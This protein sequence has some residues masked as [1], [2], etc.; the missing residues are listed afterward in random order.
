MMNGFD[1]VGL[2][3]T[4]VAC[5]AFGLYVYGVVMECKDIKRHKRRAAKAKAN[6]AKALD[7]AQSLI[8]YDQDMTRYHLFC[9]W[10][11]DFKEFKE[12]NNVI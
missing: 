6:K 3:A 8:V 5:A 4:V 9:D 1:P 12:D 7:N 10:A 2:T 11:N